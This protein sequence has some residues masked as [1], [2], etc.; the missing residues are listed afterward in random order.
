MKVFII[1]IFNL[2]IFQ[3]HLYSQGQA[4][5]PS[6]LKILEGNWVGTLTYLDY[7]SGKPYTMPANTNFEQSKNNPNIYFRSVGYSTEP[8]AN[9]KDSMIISPN[10]QMLDDF[11]I[12]SFK[13]TSNDTVE[14]ISEKDGADGNDN[15]PATIR[16]TFSITATTFVIKKE[17]LFKGSSTW[18]LRH[19]YSFTKSK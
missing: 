19:T 14:I 6:D 1:V 5:Q 17:V 18:L 9:Q 4:I 3:T 8:H 2:C 16:R 12:V 11:T 13:K 10:G 15:K 7:T